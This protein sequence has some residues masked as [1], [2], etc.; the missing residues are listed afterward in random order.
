MEQIQNQSPLIRGSH[1]S[2]SHNSISSNL[3]SSMLHL[4][5][6]SSAKI[7]ID[8]FILE[9]LNINETNKLIDYLLDEASTRTSEGHLHLGAQVVVPPEIPNINPPPRSPNANRSPKKRLQSEISTVTNLENKSKKETD[10]GGSSSGDESNESLQTT[11][12]R[13]NIDS[14][15]VFFTKGRGHK[16]RKPI[17]EGNNPIHTHTTPHLDPRHSPSQI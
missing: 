17:P 8:E 12:R 6:Y 13:S 10:S 16:S 7:K 11:R 14:I 1:Q 5:E 9:W 3:F 2:Q 15:P 4:T